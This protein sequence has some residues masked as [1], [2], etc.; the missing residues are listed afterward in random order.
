MTL[1]LPSSKTVHSSLR[2]AKHEPILPAVGLHW[3]LG[4]LHII[5]VGRAANSKINS[6]L[7]IS[8]S[9][10]LGTL[11]GFHAASDSDILRNLD[12]PTQAHYPWNKVKRAGANC[13]SAAKLSL[14]GAEPGDVQA[15]ST[16]LFRGQAY[17]CV[18]RGHGRYAPE[19]LPEIV[20]PSA[21][22]PFLAV[23]LLPMEVH[24]FLTNCG[25]RNV[26]HPLAYQ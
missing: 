25:I 13:M 20:R 6:V 16:P 8:S 17:C 22:S 15:Q 21:Q 9:A 14:I 18:R 23:H 12:W 1:F 24:S 11:E 2:Q 5:L 10:A 26:T 3:H 19:M 7:P 4:T